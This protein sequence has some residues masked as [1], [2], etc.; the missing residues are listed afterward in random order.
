MYAIFSDNNNNNNRKMPTASE[1]KSNFWRDISEVIE[2]GKIPHCL[3][4]VRFFQKWG[5]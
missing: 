1:N 3:G 5:F 2:M 4:S